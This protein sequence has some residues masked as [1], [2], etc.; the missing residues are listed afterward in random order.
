MKLK[1]LY[2]NNKYLSYALK[3]VYNL[4]ILYMYTSNFV[5]SEQKKIMRPQSVDEHFWL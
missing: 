2:E 3:V 5:K 4:I 1:Q